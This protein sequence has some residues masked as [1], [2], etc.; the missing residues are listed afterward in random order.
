M[1]GTTRN[2]E[3]TIRVEKMVNQ[4]N[5]DAVMLALRA[6]DEKL[7]VMRLQVENAL[8]RATMAEQKA[9]QLQQS[10]SK[11]MG[12]VGNIGATG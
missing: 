7:D 8:N 5:G 9:D 3:D 6:Q 4:R 1:R 12:Q 11:V 10:F 2:D